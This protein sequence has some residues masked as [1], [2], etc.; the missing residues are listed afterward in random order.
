MPSETL[1]RSQI[2]LGSKPA[3]KSCA[4]SEAGDLLAASG[5]IDPGYIA[6]MMRR[7]NV[8]N[9][10]LGHGVAIP[11]GMVE[12]RHLIH[13]TGIAVI[14]IPEGLEWNEGQTVKL[15]VAIAAQSDE[16][17]TLLRRLTR[18]MQDQD[19]LSQLFDTTDADYLCSVLNG[20]E[21]EAAAPAASASDLEQCFEWQIDYPNGLHARPAAK[22]VETARRF[23]ARIQVRHDNETAD[24]K[25][26]VSLLQLGLRQGDKLVISASGAESDV[27]L[28]AL[29]KVMIDVSAQEK[30]DADAA[31]AAKASPAQQHGFAATG[32]RFSLAGV[33]AS[34]GLVIGTTRSLRSSK[35][36]VVDIPGSLVEGGTLL[37]QALSDTRANLA[38][39]ADDT[40]RRLGAAEAGIFRA[41]IELLEDTDLVRNCCSL[42]T[43]GHGVAWSW[44]QAI[45][46]QAET[47]ARLDNPLLAARAAD[48]RDVGQQVLNRLQP[49]GNQQAAL[50]LAE[51]GV[52]LLANDLS[53]SD[54]A[55]LDTSKIVGLCTA[56]GGPTSHT[57]ILSRTLGLPALVAAGQA[58]LEVADGTAAILDGHNGRLY[59]QPSAEDI[60]SANTWIERLKDQ[61]RE[62]AA[63]STL[64]AITLDGKQMDIG[65]NITR[66]DQVG[67]AIAAGAEGVG[68]MRTEFLFLERDSAPNEE[69][70]YLSYRTVI[71]GLQGRP[72]VVRALDIG[73]DKHVPYLGLAKEENP[74]LGVRGARLLLR[75]RDLLET[76]LRA[77][78]RA[79]KHGPMSIMFP[80]IT[81]ESELLELRAE[82]ER[83]RQELAAPIVPIGIMIEVPAAAAMADILGAHAFRSAPM[84]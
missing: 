80:M 51:G 62:Q 20:N 21:Q 44:H 7:E 30:A 58:L 45:E 11:H 34:P 12:D 68:L 54:T 73:G 64:Q 26:L 66:A 46:Q 13:K 70:Q 15:V 40:A 78:Y 19:K 23:D 35:L 43:Q 81:N 1:Q 8:S 14:Q 72:L 10:F 56:Q 38:K 49:K 6:S 42:M 24:A 2:K 71:E 63:Q 29:R 55:A 31:S 9:T 69:E 82:C 83:I 37:E 79:A 65:A 16:H 47:L 39:L 17:I 41:H 5:K 67:P 50:S 25:K 57:A 4:I 18:L 48:L 76:Q 61:A 77:L 3:K 33:G 28:T 75:R 59:L 22:W 36:E 53:P 52:I 32:A 84:I 74:F 27:A 60:A